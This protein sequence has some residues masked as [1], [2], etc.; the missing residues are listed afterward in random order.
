MESGFPNEA[1]LDMKHPSKSITNF[2][3]F[4][5]KKYLDTDID[6]KDYVEP[7]VAYTQVSL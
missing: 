2:A 4:A 6:A 5:A 1:L 7:A 3:N